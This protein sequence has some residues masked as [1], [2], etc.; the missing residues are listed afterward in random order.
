MDTI[1]EGKIR[2]FYF[3]SP[4]FVSENMT[5][6]WQSDTWGNGPSSSNLNDEWNG[7]NA[8][9][10]SWNEGGA[11]GGFDSGTQQTNG[12]DDPEAAGAHGAGGCFNCGEEGLFFNPGRPRIMLMY[13]KVT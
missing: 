9:A 12:F 11:T 13:L 2:G 10:P 1:D 6:Y 4:N 5:D 3:H 8:S 7:G